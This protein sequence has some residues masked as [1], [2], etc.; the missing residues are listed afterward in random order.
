MDIRE[1]CNTMVPFLIHNYCLSVRIDSLVCSV[2]TVSGEDVRVFFFSFF[3]SFILALQLHVQ[4]ILSTHPSE[5]ICFLFS[6]T[7]QFLYSYFPSSPGVSSDPAV[8]RD[9]H[10]RWSYEANH[11]AGPEPAPAAVWT[12]EL[13]VHL[14]H[15][16]QHAQRPGSEVQQH[17]H[18]VS[19]DYGK[20]QDFIKLGNEIT[21][22]P[23]QHLLT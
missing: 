1:F 2:L 20:A 14:P 4:N 3:L 12:E 22:N 9:L 10:P 7:S 19:E 21:G 11:P 17:Q 18:T 5:N 13:R 6:D 16:G 23:L 15:P 8:H